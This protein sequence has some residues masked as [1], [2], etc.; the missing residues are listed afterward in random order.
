MSPNGSRPGFPTVQRPKVKLV[1]GS[2]GE[3][4]GHGSPVADRPEENV[5]PGRRIEH[6]Q[7][8][9]DDSV[10]SRRNHGLEGSER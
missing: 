2:G 1:L 9:S 3:G 8:K 10:M 4:I 5:R 7:A 6:V